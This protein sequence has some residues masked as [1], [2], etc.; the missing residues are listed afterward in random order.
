MREVGVFNSG[1]PV[2][3]YVSFCCVCHAESVLTTARVATSTVI[4]LNVLAA[5]ARAADAKLQALR[6]D[7]ASSFVK[8]CQV[9]RIMSVSV[10][11]CSL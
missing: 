7:W 11:E 2:E 1:L 4:A 6:R 3:V 9:G 5:A 8:H 10:R